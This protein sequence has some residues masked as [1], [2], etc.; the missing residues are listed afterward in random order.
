[1]AYYKKIIGELCYLSPRSTDDADKY[2]EWMNDIDVAINLQ[3]CHRILTLEDENEWLKRMNSEGEQVFAILD[4]A[5]DT[6]IGSCG[7]H[8]IDYVN[9]ISEFGIAIG[10]KRYW[11]KGYGTEATKLIL[12]YAFNIL[13][14]KNV[15]L[16]VFAY[17]E[18][19]QRAYEKAGFKLIGR[20]REARLM[21]G[22][23]YDI[24][25]MDCVANEFESVYVKRAF[26]DGNA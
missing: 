18:R 26:L 6:L 15:M 4:K 10:D 13:N 17:N 5:N 24:V 2:T 25:M 12:D 16:Y 11:N 1:M 7:L 14:L 20:R 21:N 9:G 8:G 22:T 23:Y 3:M 19:A